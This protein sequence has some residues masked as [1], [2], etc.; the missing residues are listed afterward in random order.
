MNRYLTA[1][2][3]DNI[4]AITVLSLFLCDAC[5]PSQNFA[6]YGDTFFTCMVRSRVCLSKFQLALYCNSGKVRPV[7]VRTL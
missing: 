7:N 3:A 4:T 6:E 2:T 5:G 1:I